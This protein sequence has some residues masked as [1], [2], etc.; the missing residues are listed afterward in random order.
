VLVILHWPEA[1]VTDFATRVL[2]SPPRIDQLHGMASEL[3]LAKNDRKELGLHWHDYF[4]SRYP[5]LRKRFVKGLEK[6]PGNS[7]RK[8]G[9][10]VVSELS[11]DWIELR[12]IYRA[13]AQ[14]A[15][16]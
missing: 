5:A 11:S 4:L 7:I 15:T 10:C 16:V 14:S 6:D 8:M 1:F 3:L 12:R 9:C 2:G 13:T